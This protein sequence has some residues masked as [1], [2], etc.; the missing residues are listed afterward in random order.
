MLVDLALTEF[1]DE[2]DPPKAHA[3]FALE[4]R[5]GIS[6]N[7]R[8]FIDSTF[9]GS[10]AA[11][12]GAGWNWFA[13]ADGAPVGFCTFEQRFHRWWWLTTWLARS[14]VGVFGPLGVHQSVRGIGL[15]SV[16]ARRTLC[17][18]RS[19]GFAYAIIPAVGPVEFYERY[20]GARV[21]ERL[22]GP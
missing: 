7:E 4:K 18:L 20:C 5:H 2:A 8:T 11:E 16:L 6:A 3:G 13:M 19:L 21:V 9:G 15:G 22:T 14:D 12:A 17:S 1:K 10:W